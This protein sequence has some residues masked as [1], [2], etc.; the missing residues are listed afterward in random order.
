MSEFGEELRR[1]RESR[2]VALA[3][4]TDVTKISSRHLVALETGH[5][6]DLPGGV[7]NKGIVRSYARVVGLDEKAW[8]DRFMSAYQSS[9]QLKDDDA[10]WIAFAENVGKSRVP[11]PHD[12]P[13][14]RLKWAGVA[15]LVVMLGALGWFVWHFV[16]DK[17]AAESDS[18]KV[19]VTAQVDVPEI[20]SIRIVRAA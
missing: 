13:R 16:S 5:F 3:S 12:R 15:V 11:E 2:G 14:M 8:V 1:E 20:A 6:D 9:G 17:L 7:F 18:A 10:S 4:I 19:G